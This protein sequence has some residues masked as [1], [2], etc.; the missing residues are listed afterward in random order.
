L[1]PLLLLSPQKNQNKI[2][3]AIAIAICKANSK[4]LHKKILLQLF[5]ITMAITIAMAGREK[6]TYIF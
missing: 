3:I 6:N 2:L 1:Q 4:A 5:S